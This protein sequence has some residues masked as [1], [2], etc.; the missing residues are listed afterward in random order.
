MITLHNLI[1]SHSRKPNSLW[2]QTAQLLSL[3]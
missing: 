3:T 2:F 1:A